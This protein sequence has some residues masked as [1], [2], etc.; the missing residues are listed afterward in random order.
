MTEQQEQ[1]PV[2][3]EWVAD[4]GETYVILGVV[5]KDGEL[6]YYWRH[7]P[8]IDTKWINTSPL[9]KIHNS[10]V[11]G[12]KYVEQLAKDEETFNG[13]LIKFD[14][15]ITLLHRP[16]KS[17]TWLA[18]ITGLDKKYTFKRDFLRMY[19]QDGRDYVYRI[20]ENGMY[21][22]TADG[23]HGFFE[24]RNGVE[25]KRSKIEVERSFDV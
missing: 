14:Y 1:Y 8:S 11:D 25:K 16:Y 7:K 23:E 2:G 3:F 24:V 13:E 10:I 21:E 18:K 12:R 9:E 6:Q 15:A 17:K 5:E 4:N 20:R 19:E 22:Y